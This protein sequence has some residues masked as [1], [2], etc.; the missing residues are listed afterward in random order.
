MSRAL[1]TRTSSMKAARKALLDRLG[2]QF[3]DG[4]LLDEALTHSSLEGS[5][6]RHN[7]RLEFL[8]D[9]VLGLIVAD[10]LYGMYKSERE[11]LLTVRYQECVKNETLSRIAR[12]LG[13][14]E[15]LKVMPGTRLT[16]NMLSD[17]LEALMGAVWLDGGMEA[18]RPMLLG[19]MGR[20]MERGAGQDDEAARKDGRP[21]RKA[22]EGRKDSKTRLQELAQDRKLELP[23]Y[24]LV[25]QT[26]PDH[27]PEFRIVVRLEGLQA[28]ASGPSKNQAEKK[29]AELLLK[30]IS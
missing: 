12:D 30:E 13:I 25:D 19:V 21:R 27:A 24:E 26:G 4:G 29:A 2:Y 9:R 8:G 22:G 23:V 28:E 10:S 7:Q 17:A 15:A 3:K 14:G 11:G 6:L 16:D 18:V 20:I 5:G 1:P